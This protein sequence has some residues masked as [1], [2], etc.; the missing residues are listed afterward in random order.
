MAD[1]DHAAFVSFLEEEC[2]FVGSAGALRGR[3]AVAAAWK[4]YYE[5]ETPPF[6]WEP[7][8]V[9]VLDSGFLALT[10]GPVRDPDG[11]E[12]AVFNSIWRRNAQGQ[13][14][15]LFDRGCPKDETPKT[16]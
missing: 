3:E 9:E 1:R 11:R 2:I 10:S 13:W 5:G 12:F 14:K 8:V 7:E 6:S 15:L 4:K 16:S